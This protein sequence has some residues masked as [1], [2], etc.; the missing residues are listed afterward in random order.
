ME[1]LVYPEEHRSSTQ[2]RTARHLLNELEALQEAHRRM[3]CETPVTASGEIERKK[4][5]TEIEQRIR[6]IKNEIRRSDR[7]VPQFFGGAMAR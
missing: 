6:R 2:Q 3:E 4:V 1:H 5:C 7:D